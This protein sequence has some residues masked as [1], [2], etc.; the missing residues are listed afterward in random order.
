VV[1]DGSTDETK[2]IVDRFKDKL[3][4]YYQTNSGESAAR[5]LGINYAEGEYVA[6]LDADDIWMPRK[7]ELQ[8]KAVD[9]NLALR[10]VACGYFVKDLTGS[11]QCLK[12][13]PENYSSHEKLIKALSVGQ[14]IPGS[15]SG[16]LIKKDCFEELGLFD[17][18]IRIGPDWDMW[19]RIAKKYCVH[20]IKEPLV[21][22]RKFND[23]PSFRT[24]I[25]EELD[26]CRVIKKSVSKEFHRRAYAALYARMGSHYLYM[27]DKKKAFRYLLKSILMRPIPVYPLDPKNIYCYPKIYRYF[28]VT[29]CVLPNVLYRTIKIVI[30]HLK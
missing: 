8:V 5:N 27:E 26:V 25:N 10:M 12:I 16:V 1:D 22:I 30:Q 9:Q 14:I 3:S 6:F 11:D 7:L 19:L 4:Y 28:L 18:N 20:F 13:V 2:Y 21:I 15:S 29:K 23:K 17:Q 24:T